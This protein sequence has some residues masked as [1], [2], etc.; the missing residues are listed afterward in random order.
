MSR[1]RVLG[2]QRPHLYEIEVEA[3]APDVALRLAREAIMQGTR[4]DGVT[5]FWDNEQPLDLDVEDL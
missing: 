4:P 2:E 5:Y 3:E 1:F